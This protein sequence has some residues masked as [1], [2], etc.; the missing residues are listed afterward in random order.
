MDINDLIEL[1]KK[2]LQEK[3]SL[4]IND[5]PHTL[6]L[7]F[8]SAD[9][10]GRLIA[11]QVKLLQK[12]KTKLPS[13]YAARC[14]LEQ[15]ALEQC[16]SELA[17][18]LKKELLDDS[19][20]KGRCL[21]LTCGLGIDSWEF[22]KIFDKVITLEPNPF[23]A[24]LARVNFGKL[25]VDNIQVINDTAENFLQHY[26]GPPFDLIYADPDR[27][28]EEGQRLFLLKDCRPDIIA[29]EHLMAQN[30]NQVM[31]KLSPLFDTREAFNVLPE[32]RQVTVVSI[33]NEVK[34]LL[35][36]LDCFEKS[37]FDKKTSS[38]ESNTCEAPKPFKEIR[39]SKKTVAAVSIIAGKTHRFQAP[40]NEVAN[41]KPAFLINPPKNGFLLEADIALYKAGLA[42][43]YFNNQPGM[44]N[45]R[46]GYFF[47]ESIPDNFM[48]KSY[49]I[50]EAWA[51][52][53]SIIKK[54]LKKRG[55]QRISLSKKAFPLNMGEIKKQL[56]VQEGG[57]LQLCI[58][59]FPGGEK[60]A[61]LVERIHT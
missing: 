8:G 20:P 12:A 15:K 14:F 7:K 25:G 33:V 51:F 9:P 52:K 35:L 45:D 54:E 11:T 24:E 61:Y 17:A 13:W 58:T 46:L 10:I 56:K 43:L 28:N 59:A 49:R 57:N 4:H 50:L 44:S 32:V 34:E 40:L 29:L 30:T 60:M 53:P 16:S 26:N 47:S 27:R 37:V 5:Y 36:Q 18:G 38:E 2:S 6:A 42:Q 23:I 21:D 1:Q 19:I 41:F 3:I 22:S 48:G 39:V 31:I 55:I